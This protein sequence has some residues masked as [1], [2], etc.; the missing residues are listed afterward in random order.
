MTRAELIEKL[1]D[2]LLERRSPLTMH[3]VDA[4]VRDI[5]DVLGESLARGMRAEIRGFGTFTVSVRSPRVGRNP[6]SG[7][8]VMVGEKRVTHF[9]PGKDLRA[10][11]DGRSA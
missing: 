5:L 4:G 7:E 10:G 11:V 3:D 9:K 6:R 8:S 2:R 1:Y